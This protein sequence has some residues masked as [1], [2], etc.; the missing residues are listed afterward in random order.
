MRP[1]S[2]GNGEQAVLRLRSRASEGEAFQLAIIDMQMSKTDDMQMSEGA[3]AAL[4]REI[5]ADHTLGVT[6]LV[7][8]TSVG[9]VPACKNVAARLPNPIKKRALFDCLCRIMQAGEPRAGRIPADASQAGPAASL[10]MPRGRV[11]I[12]EDNLVN[13]RVAKLQV[14]R[15]GFATDVVAN[16]EEAL[17]ALTRL[18]YALVLMDCQ[19]PRMD[20]Y[21]ATRELRLREDG[22]RR[23]PVIAMT[24]NA[25]AAD[26]EA[27]LGA[28]MDDYLTKPVDLRALQQM[29]DR[30][31]NAD[32]VP[33]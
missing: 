3:A 28:G 21:Q 1:E 7:M 23:T 12:A 17:A 15:L 6:Q 29:L 5:S 9:R 31:T 14:E 18:D 4:A 8:L 25:F 24:A 32:P 13:Q 30:W 11:L 26:R 10:T 20:G 16:G 2:A 19:M 33:A 27:C 22:A